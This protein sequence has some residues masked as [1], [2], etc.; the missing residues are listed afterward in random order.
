MAYGL[1]AFF[2]IG[3]LAADASGQQPINPDR[4]DVTNSAHLVDAGTLQVEIGGIYT[5]QSTSEHRSGSPI[6]LRLGLFDWI[7]ARGSLDGGVTSSDSDRTVAGFGN[8]ELGAKIR[9]WRDSAGNSLL[10]VAPQVNLP[11]ASVEKGLGTGQF[12]YLLA[13]LTGFDIGTRAHLDVNYAIGSIG[14]EDGEPRFAQHLASASLNTSIGRWSPFFETFMISRDRP[15]GSAIV[16]LNTG[17]LYL[18]RPNFALDGGVEL[19]ISDAAPAVAAFAGFSFA[20]PAFRARSQS[21]L[22]RSVRRRPPTRLRSR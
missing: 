15:E 17:T 9:V 13:A 4:P 14:V 3:L 6:S 18:L 1:A 16:A 5:R 22:R 19:G 10:A 20:L 2:C 11:T 7:E 12:D 8:V 21:R